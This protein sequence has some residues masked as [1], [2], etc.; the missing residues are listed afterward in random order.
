MTITT[1]TKYNFDKAENSI[2]SWSSWDGT[3]GK[4]LTHK[5]T[6]RQIY[7]MS[8][9]DK[10]GYMAEPVVGETREQAMAFWAE[11]ETLKNQK[12]P[13]RDEDYAEPEPKHGVNGYCRKCHSYCYGDCDANR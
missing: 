2:F 11:L 12:P 6:G 10:N 13:R 4:T 8:W 9:L 1:S 5:A 3:S 7:Q